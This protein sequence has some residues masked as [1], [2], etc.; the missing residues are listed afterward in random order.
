M[1]QKKQAFV[2]FALAFAPAFC[3]PAMDGNAVIKKKKKDKKE[4]RARIAA[5]PEQRRDKA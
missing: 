4:K 1:K 3:N 2:A 5:P